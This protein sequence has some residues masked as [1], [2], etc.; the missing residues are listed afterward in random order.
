[1]KWL[2]CVLICL[3]CAGNAVAQHYSF[4]RYADVDGITHVYISKTL[5]KAIIKKDSTAVKISGNNINLSNKDLLP[6]LDGILVLAGTNEQITHMMHEDASKLKDKK[7]YEQVIHRN[8]KEAVIDVFTR[9]SKG[10]IL[11]IILF[12]KTKKNNRI[13][14][15]IGRFTPEDILSL[16]K[17]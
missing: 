1:M 15:L 11:E 10:T 7:E 6:K 8:D 14:Q 9:E 16:M 5:L 17:P 12:D 13:I 2:I 3:C 4:N